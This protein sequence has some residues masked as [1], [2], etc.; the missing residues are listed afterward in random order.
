MTPDTTKFVDGSDALGL[1]WGEGF[2]T[3]A[4]EVMGLADAKIIVEWVPCDSAWPGA[5]GTKPSV[6]ASTTTFTDPSTCERWRMSNP[7]NP[8]NG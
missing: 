1:D 5:I 7:L 2:G 4:S 3:S 8:L 6:H